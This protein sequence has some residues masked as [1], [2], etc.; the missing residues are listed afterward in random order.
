MADKIYRN[1]SGYEYKIVSRIGNK[2]I[3][4][5][6]DGYEREA[7]YS[8]ALS[9]NVKYDKFA[10]KI[11]NIYTNKRGCNFKIIEKCG[12]RIKIKFLDLHGAE[13][14]VQAK[15]IRSGA[16][17]NPFHPEVC[18]VGYFG[19]GTYEC[20]ILID[21]KKTN[22]PAYEAWRGML[23][24]CYDTKFQDMKRP[25]YKGCFVNECWHNF[26]N[27]ALWY[28]NEPYYTKGWHLDKDIIE[29]GNKEYGPSKCTFY[30]A[31]N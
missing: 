23:R 16:V 17:K 8:N 7:G 2:V 21:G 27:F 24:R 22:S 29:R 5:F 1:K 18:G 13:K 19:V 28:Y 20:S 25:T 31:R 12:S 26:Q 15:E 9:G 3:V 30:T 11:G 6:S 4:A 14:L 10:I